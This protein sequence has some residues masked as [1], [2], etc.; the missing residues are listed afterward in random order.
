MDDDMENVIVF[1]GR[2]SKSGKNRFIYVPKNVRDV[3][4]VDN[5][6][7]IEV[8]VRVLSEKGEKKKK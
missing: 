3:E 4:D 1:R 5:W 8:S 6:G 2:V 7:V